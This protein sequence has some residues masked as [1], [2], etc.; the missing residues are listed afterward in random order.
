MDEARS[1]LP[2]LK[3]ISDEVRERRKDQSRLEGLL[4]DLRVATLT[5]PEGMDMA[6]QDVEAELAQVRFELRRAL[7][8]LEELGLEVP[9]LKPL[10]IYIPGMAEGKEVIFYWEEGDP[11]LEAGVELDAA[12]AADAADAGPAEADR[13]V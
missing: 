13:I 4:S 8:E 10:V 6:V 3:S 7:H 5:T 11:A 2:L 1:L 9:S 12:D